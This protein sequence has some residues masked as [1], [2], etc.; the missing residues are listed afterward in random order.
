MQIPKCLQNK[1]TSAY[2]NYIY[3]VKQLTA[4]IFIP[5]KYDDSLYTYSVVTLAYIKR[6]AHENCT[7]NRNGIYNRYKE[8]L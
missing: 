7:S 2:R 1:I 8:T 4:K 6:A 3:T 5:T